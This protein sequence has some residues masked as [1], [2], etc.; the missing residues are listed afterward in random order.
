MLNLF[1]HLFMERM[2]KN[3]LF[4]MKTGYVYILSNYE[5]TTLYIGVTSNLNNRIAQHKSGNGCKFTSKYKTHYLM[6]YE[7]F[8]DMN[9][10]IRREKQL[11][12]WH[13]EWKWNLIKTNNPSLIDLMGEED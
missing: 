9:D 10:A 5:R 3:N 4:V 7:C 12:R 1:Q 8:N 6:H 11:K 2:P 13:K